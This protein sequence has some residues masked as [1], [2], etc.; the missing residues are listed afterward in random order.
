M[1]INPY[2]PWG[3]KERAGKLGKRDG[4]VDLE[5]TLSFAYSCPS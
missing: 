2:E 5:K 4:I 1:A 3:L